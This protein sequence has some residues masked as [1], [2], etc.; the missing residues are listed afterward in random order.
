MSQTRNRD[1]RPTFKLTLDRLIAVL[2][3]VFYMIS[4]ILYVGV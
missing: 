4:M 1:Y 3:D 2:I